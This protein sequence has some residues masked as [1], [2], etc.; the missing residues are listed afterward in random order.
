MHFR[1]MVKMEQVLAELHDGAVI[2]FKRDGSKNGII[3]YRL[4]LPGN[5][6]RYERRSTGLTE[7]KAALS[8]VDDRYR[9]LIWRHKQGLRLYHVPFE[10]CAAAFIEKLEAGPF[11]KQNSLR[12]KQ[13]AISLIRRYLIPFFAQDAP[14]TITTER[15]SQYHQW[16]ALLY[17][18]SAGEIERLGPLVT[19]PQHV[20]QCRTGYTP[21][22]QS[23]SDSLLH[24]IL[25][26]ASDRGLIK[27]DEI[28]IKRQERPKA[29]RRGTFSEEQYAEL[30]KYLETL[31]NLVNGQ[32]RNWYKRLCAKNMAIVI[33]NSGLRLNEAMGLYWRDVQF[34]EHEG[35]KISALSVDG[36]TGPREVIALP[37][38]AIALEEIRSHSPSCKLDDPVFQG[39]KTVY[40]YMGYLTSALNDLELTKDQFGQK[41]SLYSLR[42][43]YITQRLLNGTDI[44]LLAKNAGTSVG[45]IEAHY[46]HVVP[47]MN[48]GILTRIL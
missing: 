25:V 8:F 34:I 45:Q 11:P 22:S 33:A 12:N 27:R 38:V 28:S 36:K 9:E 37:I 48:I 16:R 23:A 31:Q 40:G 20:R 6:N 5:I 30:I 21:I 32:P 44:H 18:G 43:Y 1:I 10:D 41:L 42:H 29:R 7:L 39:Y 3:Q 47:R 2:L 19:L 24:R 13:S 15:V 35:Q 14:Y 46:S 17:S 4:R 26:H